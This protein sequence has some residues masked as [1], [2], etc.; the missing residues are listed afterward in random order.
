MLTMPTKS[1]QSKLTPTEEEIEGVIQEYA[2]E[3]AKKD[4][5][6]GHQKRLSL[7]VKRTPDGDLETRMIVNS[8]Q[9][10]PLAALS[11]NEVHL[12][13]Y[14]QA[15]NFDGEEHRDWWLSGEGVKEKGIEFFPHRR[16]GPADAW[17][18]N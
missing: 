11:E 9:G 14:P 1:D 5:H 4:Y 16:T 3:L 6:N 7:F 10:T 17:T 18:D 13:R 15:D 8:K 12:Y 2:E